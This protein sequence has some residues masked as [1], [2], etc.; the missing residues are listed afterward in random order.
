MIVQF[1]ALFAMQAEFA[2]QLF[3]SGLALG[4]AGNVGED[5]GIRNHRASG[6]EP[7]AV[8]SQLSAISFQNNAGLAAFGRSQGSR[9]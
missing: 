9:E 1:T 4:L 7:R 3:V 8:S 6:F 2:D 5:G